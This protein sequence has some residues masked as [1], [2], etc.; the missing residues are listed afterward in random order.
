LEAT[1]GE[2]AAKFKLNDKKD[3]IWDESSAKDA[4][5]IECYEENT[6]QLKTEYVFSAEDLTASEWPEVLDVD[7]EILKGHLKNDP[8]NIELKTKFHANYKLKNVKRENALLR[9]D[10]V[11]KGATF[12]DSNQQLNDFKWNSGT[13]SNRENTSLSEAIRNTL[14]DPAVNPNGRVI[15]SYYLKFG[16]SKPK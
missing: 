6:D 7:Q 9:V 16:Y 1:L 11:V 15:Y 10:Y 13:V 2:L 5:I 3:T 14:Q 4:V 8:A 12:N